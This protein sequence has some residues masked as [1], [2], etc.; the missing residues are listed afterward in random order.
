VK[1]LSRGVA[2]HR[3]LR[4]LSKERIRK[5]LPEVW[6]RMLLKRTSALHSFLEEKQSGCGNGKERD[7][8]DIALTAFQW[9]QDLAGLFAGDLQ[10]RKAERGARCRKGIRR[11]SFASFH[12]SALLMQPHCESRCKL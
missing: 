6:F 9:G 11:P 7:R 3:R 4:S 12:L 5:R 10:H 8:M 2:Q 1:L